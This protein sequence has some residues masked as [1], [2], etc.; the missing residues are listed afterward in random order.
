M[1]LSKDYDCL[2]HDVIIRGSRQEVFYKKRFFKISRNSQE[3][4]CARASFLLKLQAVGVNF[5]KK[6][7]PTQRF[8]SEFCEIVKNTH[9]VEHL[10]TAASESLQKPEVYAFYYTSAKL[11]NAYL[12]Q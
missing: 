5:I 2:P 8:R 12:Y 6:E 3:N 1:E 10:R 11:L 7:T 9:F 4:T